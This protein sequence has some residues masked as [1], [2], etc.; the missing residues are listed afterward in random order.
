M[1]AVVSQVEDPFP[2]LKGNIVLAG[3]AAIYIE[4]A[5]RST[6]DYAALLK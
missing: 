5:V 6:F 4:P 2:V 1:M 3:C